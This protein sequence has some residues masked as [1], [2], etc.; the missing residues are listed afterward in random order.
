VRFGGL[1]AMLAMP[2]VQYPN[3]LTYAAGLEALEQ[4]RVEEAADLLG[5]LPDEE[6]QVGGVTLRS[7]QQ[8][9]NLQIWPP[10]QDTFPVAEE[11]DVIYELALK[12]DIA[13]DEHEKISAL[14]RLADGYQ[15]LGQL[16]TALEIYRDEIPPIYER[17][18]DV[19]G[20]AVALDKLARLQTQRA[21][22]TGAQKAHVERLKIFESLGD[23]RG[24]ASTLT[25]IASRLILY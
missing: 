5:C 15:A 3:L 1:A 13:A 21:D 2:L 4:G 24:R 12:A 19:Q 11:P 23:V 25:E 6:I 16:Q 22:F 8:L 17:I 20:R 10:K 18:G 14:E 9:R 7:P